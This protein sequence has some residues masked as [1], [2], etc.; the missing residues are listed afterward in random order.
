MKKVTIRFRYQEPIIFSIHET[1]VD[2]LSDRLMGEETLLTNG[3]YVNTDVT[4]IENV[5]NP[6]EEP[7]ITVTIRC[8][9]VVAVVVSDW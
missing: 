1:L 7:T 9:D 8:K 2:G 4:T 3:T 5:L 6:N